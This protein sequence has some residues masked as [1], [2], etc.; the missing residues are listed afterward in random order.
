[1]IARCIDVFT[2][3]SRYV[4]PS[5]AEFDLG[6]SPVYW[7]TMNGLPPTAVRKRPSKLVLFQVFTTSCIPFLLLHLIGGEAEA[8]LQSSCSKS[9][10]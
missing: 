8:F 10:S 2:S 7:K 4:L 1:M 5:W 9:C 6:R 3:L